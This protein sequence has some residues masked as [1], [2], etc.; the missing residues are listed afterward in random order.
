MSAITIAPD[1]QPIEPNPD[2]RPT[3]W[4]LR[5]APEP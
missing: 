1:S 2:D 4:V 5:R 3:R